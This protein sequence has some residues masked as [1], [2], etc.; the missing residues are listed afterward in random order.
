M[1]SLVNIMPSN[2]K[3]KKYTAIFDLGNNKV[4]R[5]NFGSK[6]SKTYVDHGDL[7]KRQ[8]YIARHSALNEDFNDPLTPASL[9][10]HILWGEFNDLSMNIQ[11][12]KNK[13]KL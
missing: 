6:N 11:H 12:F 4:K 8:N 5:V 13:F 10:M 1:P 2:A 9:S 3:N 7:I